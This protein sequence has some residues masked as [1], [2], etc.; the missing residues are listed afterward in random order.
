MVV[1]LN[2]H[3]I[4]NM[5]VEY[6]AYLDH[7]FNRNLNKLDTMKHGIDTNERIIVDNV[8]QSQQQDRQIA[9]LIY[10]VLYFVLFFVVLTLTRFQVIPPMIFMIYLVISTVAVLVKMYMIYYSEETAI[11]QAKFEA[12]MNKLNEN[13]DDPQTCPWTCPNAPLAGFIPVPPVPGTT[14]VHHEL[15]KDYS[16]N[17]WL[18]GDEPDYGAIKAEYA[19]TYKC[20]WSLG[21]RGPGRKYMP[22]QFVTTIPC[23]HYPGYR[24]I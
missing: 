5:T 7:Q 1:Q 14:L 20:E 22:P 2:P 6:N 19:P 18:H 3:L 17:K 23:E 12:T 16:T 24:R 15:S 11:M 9:A 13:P 8:I 10:L 21:P 4:I